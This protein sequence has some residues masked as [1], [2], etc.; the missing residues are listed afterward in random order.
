ML[1][2]VMLYAQIDS[3]ITAQ[4]VVRV[5]DRHPHRFNDAVG[6]LRVSDRLPHHLECAPF[7]LRPTCP[8]FLSLP[9]SPTLRSGGDGGRLLCP[10]EIRPLQTGVDEPLP[11]E[12]EQKPELRAA[13]RG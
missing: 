12:T 13:R 9:S 4:S 1:Q 3:P 2:C 11:V 7:F 8:A 5:S 6:V 10:V